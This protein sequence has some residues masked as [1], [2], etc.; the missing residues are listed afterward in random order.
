M[1]LLTGPI[2]FRWWIEQQCWLSLQHMQRT[3][4]AV[5]WD[6][7]QKVIVCQNI[8]GLK[9]ISEPLRLNNHAISS[10]ILITIALAFFFSSSSR[11]LAILSEWD[12][13]GCNNNKMADVTNVAARTG[14][15][16]VQ[17]ENLIGWPQ[18]PILP[19]GIYEIVRQGN[20]FRRFGSKILRQ[21]FSIGY[22]L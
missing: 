20:Q 16:L 10:S 21:A 8:P 2:D 17:I 7:I 15:L 4:F 14:V 3:L 1:S 13:P 18:R 5:M 11:T 12:W 6:T 9:S 22:E 19:Y